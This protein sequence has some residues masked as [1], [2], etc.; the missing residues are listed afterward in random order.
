MRTSK[1]EVRAQNAHRDLRLACPRRRYVRV[2]H[3]HHY[4]RAGQSAHRD[5]RQA[6]RRANDSQIAR[7]LH[8]ACRRSMDE[9]RQAKTKPMMAR[10]PPKWTH[11]ATVRAQC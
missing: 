7:D 10:A 8:P 6:C 4:Y 9:S 2:R 11:R 1:K 3:H 5:L